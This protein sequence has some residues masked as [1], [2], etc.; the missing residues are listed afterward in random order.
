ME[1]AK[2]KRVRAKIEEENKNK[3]FVEI[4][5]GLGKFGWQE[6]KKLYKECIDQGED[7]AR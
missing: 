3:S 1:E 4:A 2:N 6:T 7:D 5:K